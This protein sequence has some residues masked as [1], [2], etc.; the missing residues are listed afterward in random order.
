MAICPV[1]ALLPDR[2]DHTSHTQNYPLLSRYVIRSRFAFI[3][4]AYRLDRVPAHSSGASAS[5]RPH[6][7]LKITVDVA[8][9][10]ISAPASSIIGIRG[11]VIPR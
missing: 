11:L 8:V 3:Q 6:A 5:G 1:I 2:G 4:R 9:W 10:R 7:G